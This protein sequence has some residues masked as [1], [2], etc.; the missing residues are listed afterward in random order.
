[1]EIVK[2]LGEIF[3]PHSERSSAIEF[4]AS[5]DVFHG[6]SL[7]DYEMS[8]WKV[9]CIQSEPILYENLMIE[10]RL[11]LNVD[12]LSPNGP[13]L[14]E[15]FKNTNVTDIK[16]LLIKNTTRVMDVLKG[17]SLGDRNTQLICIEQ[18]ETERSLVNSYLQ[19][20]GFRF[21]ERHIVSDIYVKDENTNLVE[22]QLENIFE[23]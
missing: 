8:C 18:K 19:S 11:C 17:F 9:F 15:V 3:P 22:R 23:I 7:Y 5:V 10:R 6:N 13:S 1:M 20:K 2:R 4:G 16:I 14:D 12:C 21:Q